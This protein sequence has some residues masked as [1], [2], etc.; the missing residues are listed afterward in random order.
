[1]LGAKVA[2]GLLL[3]LA[4]LVVA[5]VFAALGTAITSPDIA[6]AWSLPA[7]RLGQDAVYVSSAMIIGIG[8]G[9]VLLASAPAIVLYFVLPIAWSMLGS[10]SALEGAARWLDHSS[11]L[12]PVT[13]RMLSATEWAHVGTSLTLWTVVPL[14]LGLGRI[15][16]SEVQ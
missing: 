4:A 6:G 5:L 8:F 13:D 16:R 1:M 2:A 15:T 11:A 14:L 10:L 3:S 12:G 9:A 7:G